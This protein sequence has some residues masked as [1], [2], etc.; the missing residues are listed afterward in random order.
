MTRKLRLK[1]GDE[2]L[3]T[4]RVNKVFSEAV[5]SSTFHYVTL[6]VR[7]CDVP[8]TIKQDFIVAEVPNDIA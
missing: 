5:G 3:L 7:G 1:A 2:V 6:R 8:V 4:A